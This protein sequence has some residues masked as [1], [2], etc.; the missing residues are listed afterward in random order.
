[1]TDA[2]R[3]RRW[4]KVLAGLAIVLALAAWW[5]DRQL[6]PTRLARTVLALAGQAQGLEIGFDGQPE[7]ALRP[8]PRLVLPRLV[9]RQ[10]GA[11]APLLTAARA[12]VALP[13]DTLWGEGPVVITR[14]ELVSPALDLEALDAWMASRPADGAAEIPTLTRGLHV[15]DGRVIGD[16]WQLGALSLDLP[17]LAPGKPA[18][19]ELAGELTME[20]RSVV[21]AG[22]L[23]L[24]SA[25]LATPFAFTG[26]GKLRLDGESPTEARWQATL[27]GRADL[28]GEDSL[29]EFD[30]LSLAGD[31][32]LPP[33]AAKG[34]LELGET[35]AVALDGTLAAWPAD[36]PP[37]PAPLSASDSPIAF[38]LAY[39]GAGDFSAP[40]SLRAS[41]DDSLLEATAAID[42]LLAWL[43]APGDAPLPPLTG[44]LQAPALEIEGYRLE[45]VD[46]ELRDDEPR[47]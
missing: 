37:L 39:A 17:A 29:F 32:P 40:F 25:G 22:P 15:A 30:T 16:G 33:L 45:G 2:P 44:R 46:I 10:P 47:E 41:R 24:E 20:G 19:I 3:K 9:V 27:A 4:P 38:R 18:E 5:I 31:S 12:E 6:E 21:F 26:A 8:E 34:R 28:R 7:Y 42:P 1:M 11:A 13:W 36:W 23:S 35:A 43:D 14:I